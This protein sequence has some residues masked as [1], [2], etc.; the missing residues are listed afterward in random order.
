MH[1]ILN[2]FIALVTCLTMASCQS[3]TTPADRP[4]TQTTTAPVLEEK[5]VGECAQL[6]DNGAVKV[7]D[8]RTPGEWQQ[9]HLAEATHLDFY[10]PDFKSRLQ[11]LDKD[12]TYVVYCAVGG[13]SGQ[14]A[15]MMHEMGFKHVIN[16]DGGIQAW[17]AEGMP[18]QQ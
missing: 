1:T 7:L 5:P 2:T 3:E 14:A 12:Q 18:L 17:K 16:M 9:G 10:Q 6:I 8:V 4:T 15:K 11:E 13:R